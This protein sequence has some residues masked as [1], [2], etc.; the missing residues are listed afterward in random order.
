MSNKV[1]SLISTDI[2]PT[3]HGLRSISSLL[4]KHGYKTR[5]IFFG[6]M[7]RRYHKRIL[8]EL[9]ILVSDSDLIGV[10]CYSQSS[11]KAI[12]LI[13]SLRDLK[14]PIVWGGCHATLNPRECIQHANI[15]CVGEGEYACLDLMNYLD[16]KD[17]IK[18]IKNLWIKD[19]DHIHKNELRP[20]ISNLDELP[21]ED[22][23]FSNQYFLNSKERLSGYR[24]Q[25]LG[26]Q[27]Y[28][29]FLAKRKLRGFSVSLSRGCP[30]SCSFCFNY[31]M[32]LLYKGVNSSTLRRKNIVAAIEELSHYKKEL[33]L[34][35]AQNFISFDDDD[36]F[37]RPLS[38]IEQF[39]SLYP[40]KIGIPFGCHVHV[41]SFN[42]KKLKLLIRSGLQVITVGLQT[43]SA[44]I[45]RDIYKRNVSN[46]KIVDVAKVLNEYCRSSFLDTSYHVIN[47]NPYETEEDVWET[48]NLINTLPKP[49]SIQ[50]FQLSFFPGS[51]LAR[52][53][54][55]DGVVSSDRE[56]AF[57]THY[58]DA[59]AYAFKRT[60]CYRYAWFVLNLLLGY[61]TSSRTGTISRW[62]FQILMH[63]K[64][65]NLF[66]RNEFLLRILKYFLIFNHENR[67]YR[68]PAF[69]KQKYYWH[70]NKG[71]ENEN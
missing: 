5:L 39:C 61:H 48:I 28:Y 57:D 54:L 21:W 30:F 58:Y 22:Y 70:N 14:I 15:V 26:A 34:D 43:G 35:S 42:E 51:W 16:D 6:S 59:F 24:G 12:Q 69:V 53:A 8:R 52:K 2:V 3:C 68:I 50:I 7:Y 36:F 18:T 47:T 20:L 41:N 40:K 45:N 64:I 4:L 65:R 27:S 63:K 10:S 23:D 33:K 49:F 67:R 13:N 25:R 66:E 71:Y 17:K 37:V 46:S 11:S 60:I 31:D 44:R 29:R 19:G 32:Q 38:D 62:L 1:I 9:K 55:A 56:L